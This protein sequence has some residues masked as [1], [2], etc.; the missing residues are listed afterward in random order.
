MTRSCGASSTPTSPR[1]CRPTATPRP[2]GCRCRSTPSSQP[3][4]ARRCSRACRRAHRM[5]VTRTRMHRAGRPGGQTNSLTSGAFPR[6]PC[7]STTAHSSTGCTS[8]A[9]A[10][11]TMVFRCRCRR[12]DGCAATP[13]SSPS[14]SAATAFRSTWADPFAAPPANNVERCA[15]CTAPAPTPTA[16]CR[17]RRA[18]PTTSAGGGE[19]SARPISHNLIPLCE[20]H[21]HLVHEGGW[22]LTMTPDRVTTWTRP[23][24][25]I[26][27]HGRT[28]DR[29]PARRHHHDP[30]HRHRRPDHAVIMRGQASEPSEHRPD[31]ASIDRRRAG[32]ALVFR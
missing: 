20:R 28:T 25:V 8:T 14:C 29:T 32:G 30:A 24:G 27:H 5:A 1:W 18:K 13:R 10:K 19:T 6:C 9:S 11:P 31:L 23:D 3:P 15:P 7:W 22:T 16:P 26:A 12:C 2:H 17:S 21:H 4:P